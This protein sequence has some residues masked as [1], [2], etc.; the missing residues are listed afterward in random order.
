MTSD[1]ILALYE[2]NGLDVDEISG[3]CGIE[4]EIV[5]GY[6]RG[7]S[8]LYRARVERGAEADVT[9]DEATEMIGIVKELARSD[10]VA[11]RDRLRAAIYTRDE[12]F[13]RNDLKARGQGGTMVQ[14]NFLTINSRLRE[15]KELRKARIQARQ[16]AAIDVDEINTGNSTAIAERAETE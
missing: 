16:Q 11:P 5:R 15:I 1:Q 7:A 3:A 10:K 12:H 4:S 13:G 6:L 2:V 8:A 9:R 14:N